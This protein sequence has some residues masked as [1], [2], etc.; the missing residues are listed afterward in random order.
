MTISP[1]QIQANIAA[2]QARRQAARDRDLAKRDAERAERKRHPYEA[3]NGKLVGF[4]VHT[5]KGF[6]PF[7]GN[8]IPD[9]Y[10][11]F[12]GPTLIR[13]Q[14]PQ[15]TLEQALAFLSAERNNLAL[16]L[17]KPVPGAS[18]SVGYVHWLSDMLAA[19]A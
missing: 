6:K 17:E 14:P 1:E 3:Y 5:K 11:S 18:V 10:D 2:T 12:I 9:L 15:E 7:I 19:Q 4:V 8:P 13:S 16:I